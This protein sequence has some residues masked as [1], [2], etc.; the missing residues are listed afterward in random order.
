MAPRRMHARRGWLHPVRAH[1]KLRAGDAGDARVMQENEHAEVVAFLSDPSVHGT[2]VEVARTHGALV[3]LAGDR[4]Y[5]LK[6]D[7]A[8]DYMDFS[9]PERRRAMLQRELDLNRPH[10]PEIYHDLVAVTRG[11]DGGL[12]L[13]G[14]GDPV[15]WV[16][17]MR[18]FPAQAELAEVARR[19]GIDAALAARIGRVVAGY[20]ADAPRAGVDHGAARIGRIVA[21]ILGSLAQMDDV[22]D[23]DAVTDLRAKTDAALGRV[24]GLLDARAA[25]GFVRR[26]HGDLHL[27][28][29]VLI[30]GRPVPFDA[31]EFDER[32]AT[33]DVLYDLAFLLM[34]LMHVDLRPAANAVLGHYLAH[35]DEPAHHDGL[36]ALPLFLALRAAIRAMV[37]VQRARLA[38]DPAEGEAAARDYLTEA[39][40]CLAPPRP[41]LVAVGGLSGSGKTTLAAGIAPGIGAAPGAVHLRSDIERKVMFGVD[42]LEKLPAEGYGPDVSARVYARL[43]ERAERALRAGH[44]VV[45]DAVHDIETERAAAAAVAARAGVPFHGLWLEAEPQALIERVS[46]RRG[47]A[48]D[49]DADV[50]RHQLAGA[51]DTVEWHMV[52]A[53]GTAQATLANARAVLGAVLTWP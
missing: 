26:C 40:A 29:L 34:D 28:N 24:G 5:K 50:V 21:D 2:D 27:G 19:G 3:F 35:A 22:L 1:G 41:V 53:S 37:A 52:D 13:D 30:E 9:T 23:A 39:G 17:R 25:A 18:R 7:I 11:P 4:A 42:P 32:L 51:P 8:Y 14:P 20:H 33:I 6:R 44:A 31:L 16:L 46:A 15:E 12:A 49:A 43:R 45:L 38:D 48:S 10:A 36:A 47:D